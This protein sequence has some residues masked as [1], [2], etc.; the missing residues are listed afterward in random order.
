LAGESSRHEGV[1]Q[2]CDEEAEEEIGRHLV[3]EVE[4]FLHINFV[5]VKTT[6][7]MG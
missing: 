3:N 5:I 1:H 7:A 2:S 6:M 4:Y